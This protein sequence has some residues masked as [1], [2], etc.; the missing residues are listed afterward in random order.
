MKQTGT[1][2]K[3]KV[4]KRKKTSL[5]QTKI[6]RICLLT[7]R[8]SYRLLILSDTLTGKT[9]LAVL[10]NSDNLTTDS[11]SITSTKAT[12]SWLE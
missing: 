1:N 11:N 5:A 6:C 7:Y 8:N 10:R 2:T 12:I 9:E 4:R 3:H